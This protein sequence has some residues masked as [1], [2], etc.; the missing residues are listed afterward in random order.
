MPT[1]IAKVKEQLA[2]MQGLGFLPYRPEYGPSKDKPKENRIKL[3]SWPPEGGQVAKRVLKHYGLG[4]DG[5]AQIICPRTFGPMH[6]C[7]VC[8][9]VDA[10]NKSED[11]TLI[12]R[13]KKLRNSERYMQLVV[14]YDELTGK[15]QKE[16]VRIWDC[17]PQVHRKIMETM[18]GQDHD[19]TAWESALVCLTCYSVG[20]AVP[21]RADFSVAMQAMKP[22]IVKFDSAK[23]LPLM[24]DLEG[25][26]VA[27]SP[28]KLQKLLDGED[29]GEA[30]TSGTEAP[31]EGDPNW[32]AGKQ[33][34][35]PAQTQPEAHAETSP[36]VQTSTLTSTTQTPAVNTPAKR[37]SLKELA[38]AARNR[39]PAQA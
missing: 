4:H 19:F 18:V 12:A 25:L 29:D 14:D 28:E 3:F 17:P 37:P 15:E 26:F 31:K 7:P 27:P 16:V 11:N 2:N 13:A 22:L 39:Q 5:K 24:P 10:A 23:W 36:P 30:E 32:S 1:D 6:A 8:A 21:K 20:P 35:K 9:W 33:E 38:E 34:E